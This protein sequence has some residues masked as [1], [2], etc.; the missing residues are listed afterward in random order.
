MRKVISGLVLA[1][2]SVAMASGGAWGLYRDKRTATVYSL[3]SSGAD[4][5]D[6]TV[7]CTAACAAAPAIAIADVNRAVWTHDKIALSVRSSGGRTVRVRVLVGLRDGKKP[8]LKGSADTVVAGPSWADI[9]LGLDSDFGLGDR[10][11]DLRQVKVK[12]DPVGFAAGTSGTVEVRDFRVCGPTEVGSSA[13]YADGD[14]VVAVPA[15][16]LEKPTVHPGALRVY[17]ALD[18]E[19]VTPALSRRKPGLVDAQQYA[20]FRE[21]L[22]E[23]AE[24]DAVATDDL[25]AADVIVYAS[26]RTNAVPAARIAERVR[27][28]G[29]PLYVTGEVLDPEVEALLPCV[30]GHGPL[31][32]F[33]ERRRIVPGPEGTPLSCIGGYS[34]AEFAVFRSVRAKNGSTVHFAF[35][36]GCDAVVEG[37]CGKGRVLYSA[38]GL[39]MSFVPGK[40][41][42][43]A[44][45]LR[46]LGHLAGR[47]FPERPYRNPRACV[48]GWSA[49]ND[50]F[51]HNGWTIGNGLLVE[52][53]SDRLEV[54][55]G[56]VL[57][58]LAAP[59]R[60]GKPRKTTVAV[61]RANPL[62]VGGV[63]TTG[64]ERV[65]RYDSSQ[66]FPGIRW[67]AFLPEVEL[68]LRNTLAF[69]AWQTAAGMKTAA[70][71][72]GER[73]ETASMAAPWLLLWSGAPEDAPLL[74]VF[75]AVP[76]AAEVLRSGR[77]V[78][79]LRL[80][81]ADG[82]VGV[83][84][85]TWIYGSRPVDTTGWERELPSDARTRIAEW[86]PR[87]FCYPVGCR[88]RFRLEEA[89]TRVRIRDDFDFLETKN[90]FGLS[91][92][93]YAVI[94]PVAAALGVR[95]KEWFEAAPNVRP[96][97]LVTR[98]GPLLLASG[99]NRVE[100]TL[101]VPRQSLAT[102]PHVSGF[103]RLD[104]LF[105][106][107]FAEAVRYTRGGKVRVD[108]AK[109]RT[110]RSRLWMHSSLLGMSTCLDNPY[111][112]S[113]ESRR[114]L[115]RRL[116]WRLFEPLE[117]AAYRMATRYRREPFS[118]RRYAIYMN[119]PR[120]ISTVYE[121]ED[122]GSKIIYGDS[123]ETVRMIFACLQK[124]A[125]RFGQTG[126]VRANWET[127]SREVISYIYAIDSWNYLCSGCVE[128]GGPG[129]IDM[130]NSEVGCM[131]EYARLAQIAG[132]EAEYAQALYRAARR[133]CP[134]VARL[135]MRDYYGENGLAER[136]S[137][138][139]CVGFKEECGAVFRKA[140][141]R[142]VN[143][144]EFFDMSQG[145]PNALLALY[146]DWGLE[147]LRR[148]YAPVLAA[149]DRKTGLNYALLAV[150]G[151][152]GGNDE[153]TLRK[154]MDELLACEEYDR[155]LR[156]DWGGIETCSW[157]EYVFHR[158]TGSPVVTDCRG[159][160]LQDA[161]YDCQTETLTLDFTPVTADAVLAVNGRTLD[162]LVSRR[163]E[164]R[165]LHIPPIRPKR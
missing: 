146:E 148:D 61:D 3:T 40:A 35:E 127:L 94:P 88:E 30:V 136:S 80:T 122:F 72:R 163:H 156:A 74:L 89:E 90:P 25:A 139:L 64:G 13:A 33:P 149:A 86:C 103:D 48:D 101:R 75:G 130:L 55:N 117:D 15:R 73:I 71:C 109:D 144:C 162:G 92:G 110:D 9:V 47:S 84:V 81:S 36:N 106:E 79:G 32:D 6:L 49:G 133:A 12:V 161:Q 19:D 165:R 65:F 29:V 150:M 17:F 1:F 31:E 28:D 54:S 99:T 11:I 118:G 53:M 51:G 5:F 70:V 95:G 128:E 59:R 142:K 111:G 63:V 46:A 137:L 38:V 57:Y 21:I 87:A 119:S 37:T 76:K 154:K 77:G 114:L 8:V 83:V 126:V 67:E 78:G 42:R 97:S 152:L 145:I 120:N 147:A 18:N 135:L 124:L 27:T 153:R 125:D 123:N 39:G 107:Q 140:G 43:D 41:A 23:G 164:R 158:L 62:A 4:A 58:C 52:N 20:G 121:P 129:S 160:H 131:M 85:P 16:P 14:S 24:G 26:C 113:E 7:D 96:T 68:H 151:V 143:A 69:A 116:A 112:Y 105:N 132:D 45:F 34:D 60:D 100:W 66:A 138:G 91:S 108:W 157:A 82:A 22:L 10:E 93:P 56:R 134:T 155:R 102:L 44:F 50:G 159:V 2:A 98:F 141:C 115:R 104:R